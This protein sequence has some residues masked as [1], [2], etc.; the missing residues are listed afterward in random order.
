MSF[1]KASV[2]IIDKKL[3]RHFLILLLCSVLIQLWPVYFTQPARFMVRIAICNSLLLLA[4][5]AIYRY[6]PVKLLP[7]L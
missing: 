4:A 3:C 2:L 1:A 7:S 5:A 6:L